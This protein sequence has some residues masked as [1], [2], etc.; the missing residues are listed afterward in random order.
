MPRLEVTRAASTFPRL[1]G[2]RGV[3]G[4]LNVVCFMNNTC[5][6]SSLYIRNFALIEE[7]RIG[8]TPGLTVMTGETGAG[9]SIVIDALGLVLGGR[10]DTSMVR[11]G[12]DKAVVEAEF[13]AAA[14]AGI[15]PLVES[16]GAEWQD[17][18]ILRRE[19]SAKSG[20]RAFVNDSPLPVQNLRTLGDRL[21]DIHGQHDHQSLLRVE[22]HREILD[23]DP[24]VEQALAAYRECYQTF[25]RLDEEFDHAIQTRDR[26]DERRLLAEH[27]L[28]EIEAVDPAPGEDEDIE[29]EL[30]MVEHAEK[31]AF[32]ANEALSLLYD[33]DSNAA[34]MLGRASRLLADIA[35]IDDSLAPIRDELGSMGSGLSELVR[36]L[37][38]YSERIDFSPDRAETLRH[39]LADLLQLTRR[40]RMSLAELVD[41]RESLQRELL[42]L[43]NIDERILELQRQVEQAR[44][45]CSGAATLL[46]M[47]RADA[48][49][50]LEPRI[51]AEL[52]ELGIQ[53]AVFEARSHPSDVQVRPDGRYLV[54][55]GVRVAC[56]EYGW[57]DVEFFLSTN[58]GEEVKPLTRVVSG[59]E[60][61]RIML[62]LKTIFAGR[63]HI[64]I[65]VFDEIDTGVSG[66]I[67]TKVGK[68]MY[69]LARKHQILTITHLPQIA[70]A[71]DAHLRVEKNTAKGRTT[72]RVVALDENARITEVARLL[73]GDRITD[74][75]RQSARELLA[76]GS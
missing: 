43:D 21:V 39:R 12:S 25:V 34:D 64:P 69:K 60:V 76:G 59:G 32:S 45:R 36:T 17:T 51:V 6:L 26:I 40:Y 3:P 46:S 16:I 58:V 30:R 37:R 1:F 19:V 73:S 20:S 72:T 66:A 4:I 8:F 50:G 38:D 70:G 23:S 10:A 22:T 42:G 18:L 56:D 54:R 31:L 47:A 52:A 75:A 53:H 13:D 2:S 44:E 65:M 9:K 63:E 49:A 41:K 74:A 28:R 61:S 24:R 33:G 67:A 11:Q 5:M 35:R 7:L 14:L 68:A 48:G 55:E 29:R 62:A 27:Q 15:R 71:G 57:E